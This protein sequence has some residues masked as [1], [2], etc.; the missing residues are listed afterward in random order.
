MKPQTDKHIQGIASEIVHRGRKR[1]RK[2]YIDGDANLQISVRISA[3]PAGMYNY[4]SLHGQHVQHCINMCIYM[5]T[6]GQKHTNM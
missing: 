6:S 5:Y 2:E 4:A 3:R 1:D